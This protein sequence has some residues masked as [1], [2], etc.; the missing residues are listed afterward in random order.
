MQ[1]FTSAQMRR[2]YSSKA[3][4][5]LDQALRQMR[6]QSCRGMVSEWLS[7]GRPGGYGIELDPHY[8]DVIIRRLAAVANIEAVHAATGKTFT[9][10]EQDRAA[11]VAKD[12]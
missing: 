7:F 10:I 12:A 9:E 11:E 1:F 2:L 3:T 4:D 8:C 6:R 5:N